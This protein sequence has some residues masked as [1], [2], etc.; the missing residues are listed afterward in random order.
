V[1]NAVW[2]KPAELTQ[3]ELERVR[4]H[5]YL[6]ERMLSF[7][8]SLAPLGTVAVQH[9]ERMD[10]SGYPRGLAGGSG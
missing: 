3:S 1:S 4:L 5:P 7:S 6:T 10:G 9:H 8:A 2:D